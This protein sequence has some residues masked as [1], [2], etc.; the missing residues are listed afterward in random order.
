MMKTLRLAVALTALLALAGFPTAPAGA[1][2]AASTVSAAVVSAGAGGLTVQ[3]SVTFGKDVF[4]AAEDP[5]GDT[6]TLPAEA[7][8]DIIAGTIV[9]DPAKPKDVTLKM[10]LA[11][12]PA[13]G[14]GEAVIYGWDLLIDG[15][16]AKGGTASNVEWRRTN[17]SGGSL[18]NP[19]VV[20]R[21]CETG[22]A[23]NTCT[24]TTV[25]GGMD[26]SAAEL[27]ATVKFSQLGANPGQLLESGGLAVYHGTG[28]LW[29]PGITSDTASAEPYTLPSRVDS[30]TMGLVQPG[31]PAPAKL[32]VATTP[33]GVAATG[34]FIDVVPTAGKAPGAYDL[35]VRA[36]WGGNCGETR[37]PVTL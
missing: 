33:S 23:G 2:E 36:C 8:A 3:G 11:S 29:F 27:S 22:P 5:A 14:I 17:A 4:V 7:G 28:M 18:A 1:A 16:P 26:S 13:G 30:V 12:L 6:T 9:S 20:L 34:S 31:F 37:V 24:G 19:F 35:V 10:K 32:P 15:A 25:P 21:T